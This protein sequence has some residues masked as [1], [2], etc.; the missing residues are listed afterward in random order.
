[1]LSDGATAN[2]CFFLLSSD[3]GY[4]VVFEEKAIRSYVS[5]IRMLGPSIIFL[6]HQKLQSHTWYWFSTFFFRILLGLKNMASYWHNFF[7]L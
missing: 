3:L 4:W 2:S 1:M 5:G 7:R 6:L